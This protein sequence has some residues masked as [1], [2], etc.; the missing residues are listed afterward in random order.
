MRGAFYCHSVQSQDDGRIKSFMTVSDEVGKVISEITIVASFEQ[1]NENQVP[2]VW[3]R[4]KVT[5]EQIE[6]H[7]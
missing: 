2:R 7:T 6:E 5:I 1:F 4:Y 3:H